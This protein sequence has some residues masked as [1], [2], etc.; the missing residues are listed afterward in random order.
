VAIY[1]QSALPSVLLLLVLLLVLVVSCACNTL[2]LPYGMKTRNYASGA[3]YRDDVAA[4][5][6]GRC[7]AVQIDDKRMSK[8]AQQMF[9]GITRV[10][11]QY[12]RVELEQV[13]TVAEDGCG[14]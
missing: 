9:L 12:R 4:L 10:S 14:C 7:S 3:Q 8:T 6:S 13:K 5:L 2:E 1:C 11:R